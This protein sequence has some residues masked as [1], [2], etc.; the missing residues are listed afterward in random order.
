[1]PAATARSALLATL[2][3]FS[4]CDSTVTEADLQKWT[5]NEVGL[6][7]IRE[8]LEDPQQPLD[9]KVRALEV[10][11]ERK[12]DKRIGDSP[13]PV[14]GNI[15]PGVVDGLELKDR[16]ILVSA[17]AERMLKH[18]EQKDAFQLSAKDAVLM[19]LKMMTPEMADRA[20][21]TIAQ[22]AFGDLTWELSPAEVRGKIEARIGPE[23]ILLLGRYGVEGAGI[24]LSH[25]FVA[26]SM[27]RY[28][29]LSGAPDANAILLRGLKKLIPVFGLQKYHLY[30]ILKTGEPDAAAYLFQLYRDPKTDDELREQAFSLGV[31]MLES[32]KVK[33]RSGPAVDELVK[34]GQTGGGEDR[35]LASANV[36]AMTGSARLAEIFAFFKDDKTYGDSNEDPGK[37]TMDFCLDLADLN[38]KPQVV[39]FMKGQLAGGNRIQKAIAL[40]C[41]KAQQA[42]D[43]KAE[44]DE[45]AAQVGK[46]DDVAIGDFLGG[47]LTLGK[48][49]Q[50][51]SEG[52]KLLGQWAAD[53]AAGKLDEKGLEYKR[54]LTIVEFEALGEEY[55]KAIEER[56]AAWQKS[57]QSGAAPAPGAPGA[58]PAPGTPAPGG[59]A[60]APGAP[61]PGA[62]A[63]APGTPAPA[64]G[65]H[66]PT[67]G[68]APH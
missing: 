17:L 58:A 65:R 46:P 64:P 61:A 57:Q 33:A 22:W 49:A 4:A 29:V 9:T 40:L 5:N 66:G 36:V 6:N 43:A 63:P 39:P 62:P 30:A 15:R 68:A 7:R 27:T 28:I 50:N 32:P 1:M 8:L 25:G 13:H 59:P 53:K 37:S 18:V 56:F 24:L 47:E 38:Q 12:L 34:I 10:M 51:T 60:P 44:I 3:A 11:V 35:W 45:L 52:I 48:L 26:E 42:D 55:G 67:P 20:Q 16:Q 41:L 14:T 31:N 54:F 19:H 21:R 2:L 23:Q